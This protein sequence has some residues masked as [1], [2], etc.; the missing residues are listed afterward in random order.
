MIKQINKKFKVLIANDEPMQLFV[1]QVIFTKHD[2]EITTAIN[3]HEA[4]EIVANSLDKDEIA[5]T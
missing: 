5:E 1:L 3:G 4:Y 2:F